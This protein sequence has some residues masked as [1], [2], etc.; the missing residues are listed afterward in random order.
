MDQRRFIAFLMLSMG[1]LMLSGLL[2]PAPEKPK[3]AAQEAAEKP[4]AAQ[5]DQPPVPA[6]DQPPPLQPPVGVADL[7]DEPAAEEPL[8]YMTLGSLD[9]RT[10][11]R[12][13]VTLTNHGG[14]VRRVEL[15]S[16]RFRDQYDRSGYLGHLEL[17]PVEKEGVRVQVVGPGTPAAEAGLKPDDVIVGVGDNNVVSIHDKE[18]FQAALLATKPGHEL[19]L[20]VVRDRGPVQQLT[21]LLRRRPM[22]VMRPEIENILMRGAKPPEGFKDPPS[23]VLTLAAFQGESL[24]ED[25]AVR[26]SSWLEEG[27]WQ[28]AEQ[29]ESSV[30]FRRVLAQWNLEI[31]KRFTLED[32][33]AASLDEKNYPGYNL[34]M[35]VE[36]RNTGTEPQTGVAYQLDGPTGLPVE[37][38]WYAH[39]IS[40][41]WFSVAGL[42]DV[43]VRFYG[44]RET[45]IDCSRIADDKVEPMGQGR[46]LCYAGVDGQYFASMLIPEKESLE[47]VWF[48]T[49]E[50]IRIGP[51]PEGRTP[52][53]YTNVTCR[54]R[55]LPVALEP[56]QSLRDSYRVFIGPK[57]PDLL[58]EYQA[59]GDSNYS[60]KGLLYYGWFGAVARI[61]LSILHFFY[62]LVG[63]YGI[64]IMM[65][66]VLVRGAMFPISFKQ[67][68]N[69]ARMQ[70]LKPELDRI[71]DKY[72]TDMQKRQQAMQELYRKHNINPLGGCLPL[73]I[74][75]PIFIGLYRSLM[76]DV[77]LRQSSLF[78]HGIRW[79]S[80]LAAPDMFLN[81]SG[82]MPQ[83]VNDGIGIFGLG[84]YLN[85]L[86]LITVALF[87]VTQKMSM[88]APTSDQ[89]ALQQKMM[90]YFTMFIGLMFFKVASGLCLYFI[91]SSL[92]GITER[93]L[94]PKPQTAG[95]LAT[96]KRDSGTMATREK[97]PAGQLAADR[98]GN[99]AKRK[100]KGKKKR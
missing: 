28:V 9:E 89:A 97:S 70:A 19:T 27:N 35:D 99:P 43:A 100:S 4:P 23:F 14:A 22:E 16:P 37:G 76:I 2:F 79:C 33:P 11:Y 51:K 71:T 32:V 52:K 45:Q 26:L 6:A 3:P 87:L 40:Q 42:R 49:T 12:M 90:K 73:F 93:K 60:L 54:M 95:A 5:A 47:D 8:R 29:D 34:R 1:V 85:I 57:R 59:G 25:D 80:D 39:K 24:D 53:T 88:P 46:P 78:G 82:I 13:L 67:T 83:S 55:R 64:A 44:A 94:L 72:R 10:G 75:F 17:Q 68:Q 7:A 15:T 21:A 41:R 36:L 20:H 91:A 50:A 98:N 66:T 58:A 96:K 18:E 86:P 61:M 81:W 62:S 92:W 65:L 63:N 38:W 48:D 74:Q 69:M 84:P 30:T 77:E 31:L 56:G